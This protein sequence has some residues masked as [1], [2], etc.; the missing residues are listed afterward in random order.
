MIGLKIPLLGQQSQ[1]PFLHVLIRA[2]EE[3][4]NPA[5]LE[6][7]VILKH[8]HTRLSPRHQQLPLDLPQVAVW[9]ILTLPPHVLGG[10]RLS[11][12][13]NS[14]ILTATHSVHMLPRVIHQHRLP[15]MPPLR[16]RITRKRLAQPMPIPIH[17][18]TGTRTTS[19]QVSHH[20]RREIPLPRLQPLLLRIKLQK[21]ALLFR[22]N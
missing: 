20:R 15:L 4:V 7:L 11:Q 17:T 3:T 10:L 21:P 16:I 14:A 13:R 2:N 9:N 8:Q 6:I 1:K 5:W 19:R 12:H 22:H 18:L